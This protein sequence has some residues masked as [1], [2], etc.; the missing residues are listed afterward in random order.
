VQ[1]AVPAT[2]A[3]TAACTTVKKL[4]NTCFFRLALIENHICEMRY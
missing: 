2:D 4:L 3:G 1:A